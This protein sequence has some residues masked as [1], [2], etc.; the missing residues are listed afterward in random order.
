MSGDQFTTSSDTPE[1]EA[2]IERARNG[3]EAALAELFERYRSRLRR[4]VDMR[5]DRRLRGRIDA[6]DVLQDAYLNLSTKL[7][8]YSRRDELPFF[9]WLRLVTGECLIDLHRRH[10]Q[11]AKRDANV[12]VSLH[13]GPM[14]QTDS[15]S[16]AAQLL[17][18]HTTASQKLMRAEARLELEAAINAMEPI[19]REILVL[20]HFEE[21]SNQ[22]T[23]LVLNVD[24]TVASSRYFRAL[25]RLKQFLDATG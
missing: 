15:H 20:R 2:L 11:A 19:D 14:P 8:G 16:I 7:E 12:E 21:L 22:E 10:L 23:A 9:L 18:K 25:R 24:P 3:D 17:G 6:S 5:M 13:R 1:V 4:M